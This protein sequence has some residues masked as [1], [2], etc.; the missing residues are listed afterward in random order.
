MAIVDEANQQVRMAHLSVVGSHTINGVAELH[1]QLLREHV[2]ADFAELWPGRFTNQTNGVTP[3]R[4]LLQCNPGLADEITQRIGPGWVTQLSQLERLAPL[5]SDPGFLEALGKIKADNKRALA[6]HLS[7]REGIVVDPSSMFDVQ[8]K[9]IHEYKRQLMCCLH[10]IWLYHRVRFLGH[11]IVPRVVLIGGKAAPGYIEAKKHIKLINDVSTHIA[12]D[13]QIGQ[14]LALCF[15]RN[16]NVS[17]AQRV[18]PAADLSEQISLAGKE[19]SGTGNMKFQMNG[20]LTLGTLDGANVEIRQEVGAENFF[21]FGL[22]VAGA[23][24]VLAGGYRPAAV[25]A[26][27][28]RLQTVLGHLEDGLFNPDERDLHRRIAG[29]L[30]HADPFLVCADFDAYCEAQ[31]R[32]AAAYADPR[33]WGGMVARNIAAAGRFSSDRTIRGYADEIWGLEPTRVELG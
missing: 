11:A 9:R 18:I 32:A 21:L 27:S 14:Q 7:H 24:G 28:E 8:V 29:Y 17:A 13:P 1:S 19:A 33:R 10:V 4:W 6:A 20:A 2:L 12:S 22:D 25:I 23:Q 16:Y 26:G 30:R 3:R 31:E 15:L 5:A